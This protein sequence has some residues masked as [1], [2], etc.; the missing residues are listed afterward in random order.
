M[1]AC[2][3]SIADFEPSKLSSPKKEVMTATDE[4]RHKY[5]MNINE[6]ET[7]NRKS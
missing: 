1:L 6:L 3:D 2:E 5:R 7:S 4:K